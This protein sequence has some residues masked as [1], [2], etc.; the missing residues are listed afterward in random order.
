M[1]VGREEHKGRLERERALAQFAQS[2]L[3]P[4]SGKHEG[5]H[6]EQLDGKKLSKRSS[7]HLGL[8]L[9]SKHVEPFTTTTTK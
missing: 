7:I 5:F 8:M 3:H 1:L 6:V 9:S 4:A 2:H